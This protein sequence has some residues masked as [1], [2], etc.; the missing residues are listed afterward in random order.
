MRQSITRKSGAFALL[1]ILAFLIVCPLVS[2]FAKAVIVDGRLDLYRAGQI[3]ADPENL[4]TIWNSLIL[5]VC[6][7]L[8]STVIAAPTAYL[9]ARTQLGRHKWLD[10]VFMVPFMTPPYIAS[11]GWILFMQKRGLFQQLFPFTGSFSE[12]FFSFGG[13]VLVMTL[14]VFPFMMTILKN[15][16]LNIP[17]SLEE[18]GAVFGAGFGARLRKIFAP[19][20]TGNYAIAAL[21]VFVKTL[22]E[23]GTPYTLGRRIGFYV[24]TTDIHRYSTTAPID[25]GKSA[26]L[27]SVLI[28]ICMGLWL[29]QNYI[30]NHNTYRLVS[31]KG[32][33]VRP[34]PVWERA[35]WRGPGAGV[36]LV[37][38]VSIGIP[39]FSIIA[40]SLIKLRGYGLAP[41]NFTLEHYGELFT[42]DKS[43]RAIGNSLF[44]AVASALIC[45]V[46]GTLVVM[47]VRKAKG[48]LKKV[49]EGVS[50]LPE[51][52]P[53]IVL[54]IG[55]MLFWNAIYDVLPLYNTMGIMVL[56]YVVLYV[57][58]T[59]QY[60]TSAFNQINDSLI[61]AGRTFGGT[62]LYVFRR[63]TLPMIGRGILGGAMMIFIIAFR[64]LV[65]ASLI[66]PPNVLVVST[67]I[68]RE[69]EQG[70]VSLGMAMAVLCV[71]ITTGALLL[72][73][74]F[75]GEKE[76]CQVKVTFAG[77]VGEHGRNCFLVEGE[78]LSFTVERC[79]VM[80]GAAQ[81]Y[82]HLAPE[83]IVPLDYIFLTHSHA[84]H[85][86]ALPWFV[87]QGFH[88]VV[89]ASQ[90]TLN[91][92]G[93]TV[94]EYQPLE[95]FQP[96]EGLFLEWGR[97]GHCAGSV[98]YAF[99]L[100]G[101]R[102]LF[103]GD[104]TESSLVYG[105]DPIRGRVADL[106]VLDSAYGEEPRSPRQMGKDFLDAVEPYVSQK[107]AVLFPVPKYGRGQE[108]LLLL[109]A[110]WPQIPFYGD[111]H[112]QR[113]AQSLSTD[114][115]WTLPQARQA[116]A[117]VQVRPLGDYPPKI[118]LLLCQRSPAAPVR[119]G[120]NGR[121]I[122]SQR[123]YRPHRFRGAGISR[124]EAD[125]RGESP[126]CP[127]ACPLHKPAAP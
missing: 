96:P 34:K 45:S 20:L 110:R 101:I 39:Y 31:G 106:A 57:P 55:I 66:A 14:N 124:L 51:M 122:R 15:A 13:L 120:G 68:N 28:V 36:C 60:V 46:L 21:L 37:I 105:V 74:G 56:A 121:T 44:L 23:Y 100:E 104:Y 40:S 6:V 1:A 117:A 103:S 126:V 72:M 70:S 54:V 71:L 99:Q 67:Y 35:A 65:T 38:L 61:Q 42:T 77:G 98:W 10:I 41:G 84:D 102:L 4:Q 69:F 26:S 24:F 91:Q 48:P 22:S 115:A 27:S 62:P 111:G 80:V 81:P 83:Q 113:Q 47:A 18:S 49:L 97:A 108:I 59:V 86:G 92:L 89:V 52:L 30:T 12:G 11:M 53:A 88:G 90:K 3:I 63:V 119:T 82:P 94:A 127:G 19:L 7:T 9:L 109:Q 95:T 8:C 75:A 93:K 112:F 50:L 58:Y 2:V 114:E 5:G 29:L 123:R 33:A 76:G 78:S 17:A 85:T 107:K 43:L 87:G 73:N 25:F 118:R 79:V 16:I 116:L 32:G 125:G 64:E